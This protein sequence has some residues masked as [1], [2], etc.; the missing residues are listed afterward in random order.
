M[1][2]AKLRGRP[3]LAFA[4]IGDPEKFFATSARPASTRRPRSFSDHHRYRRGEALDLI[5]TRRA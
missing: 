2:V 5:K 1:E 3:V 4:G